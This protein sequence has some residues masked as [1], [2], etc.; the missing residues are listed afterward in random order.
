MSCLNKL[1]GFRELVM[2]LTKRGAG[3]SSA[4]WKLR[5]CDDNYNKGCPG[6]ANLA[7]AVCYAYML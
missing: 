7:H 3:A 6:K 4:L 2:W 5:R 1:R